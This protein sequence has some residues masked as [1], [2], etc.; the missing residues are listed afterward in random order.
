M[1]ISVQ[2]NATRQFLSA[3]PECSEVPR[4]FKTENQMMAASVHVAS[5]LGQIMEEIYDLNERCKNAVKGAEDAEKRIKVSVN[6]NTCNE[7]CCLLVEYCLVI[8]GRKC[9]S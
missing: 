3:L 8:L 9:H 6:P 4:Q 7:T 5:G 1:P 2:W